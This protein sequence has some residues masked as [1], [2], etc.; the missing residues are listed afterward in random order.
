MFAGHHQMHL[1]ALNA[2]I[3]GAGGAAITQMNQA[4]YNALVK[5]AIDAAKTEAD[6]VTLALALEEAAA[7]TYV[8]AGGALSTSALRSTIMTIGGVEARHAAVLRMAALAQSP[9]DV[10]PGQRGFFPGDNPLAGIAGALI[11][12]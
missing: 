8:Y 6:A 10:F 3:T 7:Q 2:V 12:S 1:D 11:T 4:V 9:L 5:P